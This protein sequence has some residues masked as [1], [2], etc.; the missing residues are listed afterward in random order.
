M[1]GSIAL[2][3]CWIL[4]SVPD[5]LRIRVTM[6]LQAVAT[7]GLLKTVTLVLEALAATVVGK[8]TFCTYRNICVQYFILSFW[9]RHTRQG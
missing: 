8:K 2:G 4:S 7:L 1:V 9:K 5:I 3:L 6:L